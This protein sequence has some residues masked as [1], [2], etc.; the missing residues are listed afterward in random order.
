MSSSDL[1]RWSGLAALVGS[2]L[3]VGLDM[4]EFILLS[5]Q[6]QS[7]A[8]ATGASIIVDVSFLVASML[9]I[10]GLVGLYARQ[11]EQAGTLGLIA[12]L[13]TFIGTVMVSGSVWSE[14]FIGP[15]LAEA[16][17]GLL[18][19]EPSGMAL[20]GVILT[21]GLFSLGWLLFGIASL[22][23]NVL[24]RGSAWLLVVGAALF[25]ALAFL[26]LPLW[27]LVLGVGVAWMGYSLWSGSGN[28]A[29][30]SEMGK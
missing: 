16:A 28:P 27:T 15:T 11:A 19:V 17:P 4:L 18:D 22:Q 29:L 7:V 20:A 3:L 5:G 2:V 10:L 21:F 1:T 6:P 26:E 23:A 9:I 13:V 8:A 24:P 12:F 30:E 25:F 14:A